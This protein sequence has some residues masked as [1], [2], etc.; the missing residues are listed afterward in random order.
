MKNTVVKNFKIKNDG[1]YCG[2]TSVTFRNLDYS[3]IIKLVKKNNLHG[4]EWGGD[5]HCPPGDIKRAKEIRECCNKENLRIFSYGSYIYAGKLQDPESDFK[6]VLDT[7]ISLGADIIRIWAGN[8]SPAH[9]SDEDIKKVISQTISVCDMAK[10]YN[11]IIAFEYHRNT[12]TENAASA[13]KLLKEINRTNFALYWQPNP[14]ISFQ[15]NKHELEILCPFVISV[16]LFH[17]AKSGER[18]PLIEGK[19]QWKEYLEVL[20]KNNNYCRIIMEFVKDNDPMQ[21]IEDVKT[22]GELIK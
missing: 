19:N 11:I 3:E 22:L 13:L 8:K 20:K 4:I 21:F 12:L 15:E 14:D 1:F 16:H 7:A 17:W 9:S 2:L 10:P 18:L 6:D 5:I